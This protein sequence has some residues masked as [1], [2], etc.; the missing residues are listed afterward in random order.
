MTNLPVAVPDRG[1]YLGEFVVDFPAP[2]GVDLAS[3][4]VAEPVPRIWLGEFVSD[5]VAPDQ[6]TNGVL[7]TFVVV[8]NSGDPLTVRGHGLKR[9][10]GTPYDP[11]AYEVFVN[12][13]GREVAVAVFRA[14]AIQGIYEG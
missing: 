14:D 1:T 9:Q 4:P 7:R 11:S 12:D 2:E 5:A 6:V 3:L 10:N 13:R 8:R